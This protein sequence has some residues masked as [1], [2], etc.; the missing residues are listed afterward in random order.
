MMDPEV[1][2]LADEASALGQALGLKLDR[3]EAS[4]AAFEQVLEAVAA[5]LPELDAAAARLTVERFGCYLLAVGFSTFGGQFEWHE[6]AGQPVLVVGEPAFR[7]AFLTWDKVEGRLR[8]Q[9]GHGIAAFWKTFA[10]KARAKAPG[11]DE[12]VS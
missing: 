7:V 12:L 4:L 10:Q 6:A 2:R 5:Y 9:P 3:T 11:S 8:R 1:N